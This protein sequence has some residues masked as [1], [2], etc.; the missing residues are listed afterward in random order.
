MITT[1]LINECSEVF[2]RKYDTNSEDKAI[3]LLLT[4]WIA[5]QFKW[6]WEG[7]NEAFTPEWLKENGQDYLLE[8]PQY[9]NGVRV[10][11]WY[12]CN[13]PKESDDE[14]VYGYF[15]TNK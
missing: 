10:I 1:L 15:V 12:C 2:I 6:E 7:S 14:I 11:E 8:I 9:E 5:G 13:G 4:D 3:T